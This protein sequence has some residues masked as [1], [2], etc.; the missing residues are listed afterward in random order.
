[1]MRRRT[2]TRIRTWAFVWFPS[3]DKRKVYKYYCHSYGSYQTIYYSLHPTRTTSMF[4]TLSSI[5]PVICTN[6][7][8]SYK[9]VNSITQLYVYLE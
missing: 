3:R 5:Y 8:P 6:L 1:M 9:I 4:V 7:T 2:A